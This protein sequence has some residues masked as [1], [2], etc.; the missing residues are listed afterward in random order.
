AQARK[1]WYPTG[2]A[3]IAAW[4]V[5]SY[6]ANGPT[7]SGDAWRTVVAGDD[8]RILAHRS[9]Q[10]DANFTYR[11]FANAVSKQM[12]DGPLVDFSP[13]PTG[14]PDGSYPA[15]TASTLVTVDSLSASGDPWLVA[16]RTTTSGNN[17]DTYADLASPDGFSA[18]DFR[19]STTS[20]STFDRTYN[21]T[22][23]ANVNQTQQLAA[24]TALFYGINWLHDFW[25]DSGFTEAA[26]NAQASNFGRGGVEGDALLAEAQDFS[27]TDNANMSTPS[28]GMSPRM[29]VYTWTHT[30][31]LDGS[32]DATLL[33]HEFGH[34]LHHRTSLCSTKLCSALSEGYGDFLAL[35]MMAR[36]GDNFA[37]G[38]YPFGVYVVQSLRAD[39]GYTGIRRAPYSKST[40]LN[41][42]MFRHMADGVALPTNH[43]I[44]NLGANSN[45]HNAGEIWAEVL[46]EAY[47]SIQQAGG[48]F[49]ENHRKMA[50]YLVTGMLLMPADHTPTEARDGILAA[51]FTA[52]PAD[53]LVLAQAFARRGFGTCAV[54]PPRTSTTNAGIVE[55]TTLAGR[56]EIGAA[57]VADNVTTC[58][59][60][61]VL[62]A[63]E[64]VNMVV[65]IANTGPAALTNVTVT[66]TTT[67]P[68]V[69][70]VGGPVTF[71]SIPAFTTRNAQI[72]VSLVNTATTPLAGAFSLS[73]TSM[74]G[75]TNSLTQAFGLRMNVDD[76]PASSKTDSFDAGTSVWT[77]TAPHWKHVRPT[78]LDGNWHGD[79]IGAL[80]DYSLVSPP[81][82]VG[83]TAFSVTF[84]QTYDFEFSQGVA[85]DGGVIELSTNNGAT[86]ADVTTFGANPMYTHTIT[87]QAGNPLANR[88]AYS[89]TAANVTRT[90]SFGTQF[91]GQTVRLRFRIGTDQAAS[92]PG[93]DID[94]VVVVGI[95]GTPFPTQVPDRATC[96]VMVDAAVIDARVIDAR[97]IDGPVA[98]DAPPVI[99]AAI[100][101]PPVVDA[102]ID[103][104]PVADAAPDAPPIDSP[105]PGPDAPGNP[106]DGDGGGCCDSR[107]I[108]AGNLGLA[109]GVFALIA[110]R[111][112]RKAA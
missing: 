37:T 29:Q 70:I 21:T 106:D 24:T 84:T 5:D 12:L 51:A 27:G 10:V 62:D 97:V 31:T 54:S 32:L 104:P 30:P 39:P 98:I 55:T 69:T 107:P 95:N 87:D 11:V 50:D 9:I 42:L 38:A 102:A 91:S 92:A 8:S 17:T 100:D 76:I 110:L 89:R 34:Y 79:D 6:A 44:L 61:G 20:A 82:S 13:H 53:H 83:A 72:Q 40:N 111:R 33:A 43:P 14:V 63:G 112:R 80:A 3:L 45:V 2:G 90:L 74:G 86:W 103:A 68:G 56:A 46:W 96:G 35:M 19:A 59:S 36:A 67:T 48:T 7:T 52:S 47:V 81:L 66:L 16:G 26:G 15:Y 77:S 105:A 64:T 58:D 25:Y 4:V 78:A 99:D 109:F 108:G 65:P 71:A 75:C 1:V 94:D 18:G 73:V 49:S 23:N 101:A 88:Q 22:Q 57:T 85:W 93:W 60:D 28:D 41:N